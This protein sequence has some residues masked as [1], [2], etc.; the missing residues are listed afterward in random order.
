[1]HGDVKNRFWST[2]PILREITEVDRQRAS[3]GYP[4]NS[5]NSCQNHD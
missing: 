4:Q 2:L 3:R 5:V 1:V